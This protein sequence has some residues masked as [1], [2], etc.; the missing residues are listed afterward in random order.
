MAKTMSDTIE[1]VTSS[2]E[3]EEKSK[4]VTSTSP[5]RTQHSHRDIPWDAIFS[6]VV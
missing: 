3:E 6:I 5:S 1:D 4:H 2:K